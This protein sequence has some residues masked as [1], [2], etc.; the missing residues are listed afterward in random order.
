MY[1]LYK[2]YKIFNSLA[3]NQ[4]IIILSN[5]DI[6]SFFVF[7]LDTS[8]IYSFVIIL[9]PPRYLF[10]IPRG[11][12][13]FYLF[14]IHRNNIYTYINKIRFYRFTVNGLNRFSNCCPYSISSVIFPKVSVGILLS[15]IE[16]YGLSTRKKSAVPKS[17]LFK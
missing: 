17:C 3:K 13:S 7:P 5:A 6:V 8:T 4:T 14:I 1:L 16:V 9:F 10:K 15:K 11:T 2:R 12:S